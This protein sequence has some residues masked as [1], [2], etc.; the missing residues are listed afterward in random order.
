MARRGPDKQ[1]VLVF[2][3]SAIITSWQLTRLDFSTQAL[4]KRWFYWPSLQKDIE[5]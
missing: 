5:P 2:F 1:F 3:K 4:I